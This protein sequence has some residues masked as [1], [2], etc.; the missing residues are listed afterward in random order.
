M[1]GILKKQ[2]NKKKQ[3]EHNL[4][5]TKEPIVR[6]QNGVGWEGKIGEED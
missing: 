2:T 5:D 3:N 6:C 1:C 4:I